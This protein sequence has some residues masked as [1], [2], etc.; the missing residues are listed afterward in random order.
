MAILRK[1]KKKLTKIAQKEKKTP[2][3]TLAGSPRILAKKIAKGLVRK[4][5]GEEIPVAKKKEILGQQETAI[6][7]T[8]FSTVEAPRMPR[9]MLQELPEQYGQDKV[10]LQVRDPR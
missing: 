1:I 10:V 5:K 9:V 7:K 3:R 6:G 4:R 8:K 2:P